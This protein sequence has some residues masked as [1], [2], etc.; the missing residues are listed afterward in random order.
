MPSPFPGMDPYLEHPRRF[1]DLHHDLIT[2][3]K[4]ALQTQLPQPYYASSDARVWLEYSQRYVEPDV[5]VLHP[6]RG[7]HGGVTVAA[8]PA[9][10]VVVTV[11]TVLHR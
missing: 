9:A 2:S 10:P 3:L 5:S 8:E 4:G 1:P 7:P 11:E 6:G